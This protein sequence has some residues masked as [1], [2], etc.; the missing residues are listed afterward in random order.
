M[1]KI[2][3]NTH[4]KR[5]VQQVGYLQKLNRDAWP[6]KH[7]KPPGCDAMLTGK[8]SSTLRSNLPPP[9]SWLKRSS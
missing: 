7:K 3:I 5:I 9:S 1:W 4:E 6:T 2:K 8:T